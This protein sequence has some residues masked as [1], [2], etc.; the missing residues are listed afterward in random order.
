MVLTG[1]KSRIGIEKQNTNSNVFTTQIQTH[2]L[3]NYLYNFA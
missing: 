1:I 3:Y 2:Y